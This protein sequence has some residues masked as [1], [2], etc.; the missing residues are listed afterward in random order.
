MRIKR[1]FTDDKA[2][3]PV[4]AVILMVAIT[5]ILASIVG[6]FVLD[7]GEETETA[8]QVAFDYEFNENA[9]IDLTVTHLSGDTF[10]ANTVEFT[11]VGLDQGAEDYQN[12]AWHE[13]DPDDDFEAGDEIDAG[14][15]V[16]LEELPDDFELDI[17][18]SSPDTDLSDTIGG[19]SGP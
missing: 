16:T 15:A 19:T 1:L 17:V 18:W 10:E 13:I 8:P 11:G 5:V 7:L 6:V 14:D 9:N 2:V 3:S 4:I 12:K